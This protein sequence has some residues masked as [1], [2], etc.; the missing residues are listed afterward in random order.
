MIHSDVLY[1]VLA[2]SVRST[3]EA[4]VDSLHAVKFT[5][6][7]FV[8]FHSQSLATKIQSSMIFSLKPEED[9]LQLSFFPNKLNYS[10]DLTVNLQV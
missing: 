2:K 9:F 3:G 8:N 10:F 1:L 6:L 5:V 4:L 7:C